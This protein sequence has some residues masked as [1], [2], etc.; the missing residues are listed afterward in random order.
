MASSKKSKVNRS[1]KIKLFIPVKDAKGEIEL[2]DDGREVR[3]EKVFP[4][5]WGRRALHR[6]SEA[7]YEKQ[8]D[9]KD[10]AF[11]CALVWATIDRSNHG[12]SREDIADYIPEDEAKAKELFDE[13]LS[14][15]NDSDT[16]KK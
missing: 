3:E 14:L 7:G 10:F 5:K 8:V 12:M 6:M 4:V 11:M 2:D 1:G 13:V 9:G 16:G 15:I